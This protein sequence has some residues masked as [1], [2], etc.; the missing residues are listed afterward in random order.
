[1]DDHEFYD[2]LFEDLQERFGRFD[3]ATL[4][5][6]VGFHAG[7]PISLRTIGLQ[8]QAYPLF[9]T[10]ELAVSPDQKRGALGPFELVMS[11]NDRGF[12]H[13]VL[14]ALGGISLDAVLEPGD[15]IDVSGVVDDDCPI[16]GIALEL[17]EELEIDGRPYSIL[18]CIGLTSRQLRRAQRKGAARVC[19][20]LAAAGRAPQ[21]DVNGR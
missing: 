7:G 5:A 14:T 9:A 3:A 18:R 8:D 11:V 13:A 4:T 20:E 6:I 21:I 1:M 2:L 16:T 17:E 10:C 12:A 15:T 19:K